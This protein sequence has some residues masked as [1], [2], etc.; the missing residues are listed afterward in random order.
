MIPE[1]YSRDVAKRCRSLIRNLMPLIA[2]GL[3]DDEQFGGPL[4][5]TF[6]LAMAT[7]MVVLPIE[8][9]FKPGTGREGAADDRTLDPTLAAQVANILAP[10]M[11]FGTAPFAETSVWA[12]VRKLCPVQRG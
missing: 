10:G 5:T 2:T 3:P 11:S 12:Y 7:P 4:C 8:R 1:H 6:L 9:M